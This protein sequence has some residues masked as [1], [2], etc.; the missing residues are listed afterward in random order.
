MARLDIA[1]HVVDRILNQVSGTIR[2]LAAVYNRHAYLEEHK[3]ALEAW[4]RYVENREAPL[5]SAGGVRRWS[6]EQTGFPTQNNQKSFERRPF[7]EYLSLSGRTHKRVLVSVATFS[8]RD[9]SSTL[10]IK[11]RTTVLRWGGLL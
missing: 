7:V 1:P 8:V 4:G 9:R 3:A 2:G 5:R 10:E 11:M 6:A